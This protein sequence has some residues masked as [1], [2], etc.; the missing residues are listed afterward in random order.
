MLKGRCSNLPPLSASNISGLVVTSSRSPKLLNLE[1][2]SNDWLS[3][4]PLTLES[5]RLE[6]H[7]PSNCSI[8]F[9]LLY[10]MFSVMR[11]D[12]GLWHS[13]TLTIFLLSKSLFRIEI[14]DVGVK[15]LFNLD[16]IEVEEIFFVYGISISFP[17]FFLVI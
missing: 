6:D 16:L 15:C 7:I 5:V 1:E 17:L 3:G 12:K 2:K 14:R 9:P 11:P 10:L 13:K 8:F 4:L